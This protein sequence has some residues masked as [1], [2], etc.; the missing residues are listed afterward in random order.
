MS[1]KTAAEQDYRN[2]FVWNQ[3]GGA[4]EINNSTDREAVTISHFSGSNV[5]INNM[6]NSEFATNNKQIKVNNDSFE[7]V[8]NDKNVYAGKDYIERVVENTYK[9][10]GFSN[11]DEIDAAEEWKELYRP[12]AEKNSQFEILRGGK[13]YP[14]GV[15]TPQSGG[16][17]PNSTE[18]QE[19]Y[20]INDEY[21]GYAKTP[22]VGFGVDEVTGYTPV[23]PIVNPGVLLGVNPTIADINTGSG[24]GGYASNADGV[25][26]YGPGENAATEEG[27]WAINPDKQSIP[28]DLLALQ[29]EI[30]PVE[31]R[32]GNGGDEEEFTYRSKLEVVGAA[33]ND[34]P[35]VR[36]DPEGRSQP[37]EVNVGIDT[38]Y[39]NVDSVPHVEEVDNSSSFP[40]GN[41][42][43][44]VGNKYDVVV[45]SGGI[46]L[47]TSGPVEI[48]GT[49]L[50]MSAHKINLQS[51]AGVNISSENIVELQSSKTI[52]LRS[53]RQI[54]IEPGLGVKNNT[55]IGGSTYTEGE[56]YVHHVTAPVEVQQT[57]ETIVFSKLLKGLKFKATIKGFSQLQELFEGKTDVTITL[58]EDSNDDKI[59]AYPHSHHFNNLPLRLT[60]SNQSVRTVAQGEGININ[61]Y[62][63]HAQEITH[64]FKTPTNIPDPPRAL[65][66]TE[67]FQDPHDRTRLRPNGDIKPE[68][69]DIP[70]D[71]SNAV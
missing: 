1:K 65:T 47:K 61:G 53:N 12:I 11:Q 18:R 3:R 52:A 37:S 9:Y 64:E 19:H 57:H 48:G 60:D 4:I 36:I 59:E 70:K 38:S 26:K 8:L 56:T 30:N 71:G 39:V 34:Y 6:V 15:D 17:A 62:Q 14:N 43:L 28:E 33:T 55:I 24:P 63:G 40:V 51:A 10:K 20:V 45:G 13:S 21:P 49:T 5:K 35:S 41:Y 42:T 7:T 22:I 66:V 50:K 68:P 27:E 54:L 23:S 16:R 58:K 2:K 46:Q 44:N 31:Q 29:E 32:M 25:I 67:A 69:P